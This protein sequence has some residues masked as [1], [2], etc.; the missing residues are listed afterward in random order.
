M[1][2]KILLQKELASVDGEEILEYEIDASKPKDS[3]FEDKW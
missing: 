2:R 1:T 3:Q